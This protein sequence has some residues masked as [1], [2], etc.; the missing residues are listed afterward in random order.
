MVTL[1]V[2]SAGVLVAPGE[3]TAALN[4]TSRSALC[5]RIV[6]RVHEHVRCCVRYSGLLHLIV[7]T[8]KLSSLVFLYRVYTLTL[9]L[10]PFCTQYTRY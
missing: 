4:P 1:P 9:S 8:R 3:R 10:I 7:Q 5:D 6:W 2:R